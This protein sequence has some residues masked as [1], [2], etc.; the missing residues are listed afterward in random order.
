[1]LS[2]DSTPDLVFVGVATHDTIALVDRYPDADERVVATELVQAGGGPAATAAV[3]ASRLG[4]SV[5][6]IGTVGADAEG[7][8]IL[9][10]LASEGVDVSGVTIDARLASAAS[11]VVVEA[12]R[13]TRAIVNRPPPPIRLSGRAEALMEG[14]AWIHVDQ[15][16][17]QPVHRWWSAR[18]DR[19]RLSVDG[20][21]QIEG[22]DPIGVDL[23][24]PTIS[25]LRRRLGSDLERADL[26]ARAVADGS[27]LVVATDGRDGSFALGPDH[28]LVHVPAVTGPV[29]S[30]LGAGDVFHGA[31]LAARHRGLGLRDCLRYANLVAYRSCQGLDGRS[32]IPPHDE[33]VDELSL[34]A[35]R[36]ERSTT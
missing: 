10:G 34:D 7:R 29:R 36:D 16:G 31:L 8:S 24:V 17:W 3:A 9:D 35:H 25:A 18:T 26:L 19:P 23:Y 21:N 22:F 12:T 14:A 15:A 30:T 32:A 6:F 1:M 4:H 5:A 27:H 11:L 28:E 20:G 2:A 13:A 33:V